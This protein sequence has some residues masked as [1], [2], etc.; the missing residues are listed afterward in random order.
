MSMSKKF[1]RQNRER[2]REKVNN[3]RRVFIL[4]KNFPISTIFNGAFLVV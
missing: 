2:E 3:A 1:E 4:S